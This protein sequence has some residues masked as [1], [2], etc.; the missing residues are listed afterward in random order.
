[1]KMWR[2]GPGLWSGSFVFALF[3]WSLQTASAQVTRQDTTRRPPADSS[4]LIA[5]DSVV[6]PPII[7]KHALG[8]TPGFASG[9]YVWDREDLLNEGAV[10]LTE[11]LQQLPSVVPFRVGFFLQTE[12]ATPF[13]QTR[14]RLQVF[15][16]GYEL[17]PLLESTHDLARIELANLQQVRIERRLDVTRVDLLSL[18]PVDGRPHSRI[19]AGVG[20]P[21]TN[22]FRGVFLAPR[23]FVGPFGFSIERMDTDGLRADEPAENSA[24]WAK[25]AWIRG[26]SGVQAEF[27]QSTMERAPLS[28]WPEDAVRRD[29]VL[30]A[31]AP[32]F[33]GL[34]AEAF[35]GHSDMTSDTTTVADDSIPEIERKVDVTQFGAR[36]SYETEFVWADLAARKRDHDALPNLQFDLNAGLRFS[37]LGSIAASFSQ[38]DWRD[39][40]SASSYNLRA[41]TAPF[42]G[43]HAFGEFTG[44]KRGG[45]STRFAETDSVLLSERTGLRFGAGF[46]RWGGHVNAALV[47]LDGDSVQSF[48]LPFDTTDQRF[49]GASELKGWE[50]EWRAPLFLKGLFALGSFT[51]FPSGAVPIYLPNQSWRAALQYHDQPL[52]SDHLE[53]LARI[54]MRR[55]GQLVAVQRDSASWNETILPSFDQV[56]GYLQIRIIDVRLWIRAENMT[57][58]RFLELPDR[59]ISGARFMYG[60]KWSFWN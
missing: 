40:G 12:M 32:L 17:D 48:G 25:W 49:R 26:R 5:K 43:L 14:G 55:R 33:P 50:I 11:L 24:V 8:V 54:E 10:T 58:Q 9:V 18:E 29:V 31:R 35:V 30:R 20:E 36:A 6:P 2:T 60:V 23:L 44:G 37:R 1:M 16:D 56:D 57:A 13:A 4:R 52:R 21:D 38:F 51:N 47:T 22:L 53:I 3:L 7:A 59:T 39:A 41:V 46:A 34:V 42:S 15:L 19:E 27:R 28:P 45:P